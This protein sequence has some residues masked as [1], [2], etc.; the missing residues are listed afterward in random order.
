MIDIGDMLLLSGWT[1]L[2]A[3]SLYAVRASDRRSL[4]GWTFLPLCWVE[5]IG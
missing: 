5:A 3:D 1:V 2:P 4:R